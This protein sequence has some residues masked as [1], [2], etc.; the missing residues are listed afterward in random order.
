MKGNEKV[1]GQDRSQRTAYTEH[2][3]RTETLE[4]HDVNVHLHILVACLDP[5]RDTA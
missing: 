4:V 2:L 5:L 3:E 1:T